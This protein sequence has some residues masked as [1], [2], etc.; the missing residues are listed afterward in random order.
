MSG[1]KARRGLWWGIALFALISIL[2]SACGG[3]PPEPTVPPARTVT[4]TVDATPTGSGS[5][6]PP[7]TITL[8]PT[9][10]PAA[11]VTP[12]PT[13]RT[14]PSP[15]PLP[16]TATLDP[17]GEAPPAIRPN[18]ARGRDVILTRAQINAALARAFDSAPFSS[19]SAAPTIDL[20]FNFLTLKASLIPLGSP[21]GA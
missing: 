8:L 12:L 18:T 2:L 17:A 13:L 14:L 9:W 7:P 16:P 4:A 15:T 20:G 11:S 5:I 19:Y 1:V 3:Q 6:T 10:T 21:I